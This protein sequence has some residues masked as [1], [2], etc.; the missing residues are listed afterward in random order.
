MTATISIK[1]VSERDI[2]LL[3]LEEFQSSQSFRDWFV[4][5]TFGPDVSLG[6]FIGAERS[7][8]H[9]IGESD[10]EVRFLGKENLRTRLMIENKINASL[11][12]MQAERYLEKG[13]VYVK[14]GKCSAFHT[15]IVAPSSYFGKSNSNK[16]FGHRI[17]YEQIKDW[18]QQEEGLGERRHYK[19]T[20]LK[21]AIDKGMLGYQPEEDASITS[22]WR[23][24]WHLANGLAP[25]LEMREPQ[26]K[27]S[28]SGFVHFRPTPRPPGVD[29]VHKMNH[30]FVDLHLR[31]M[32]KHVNYVREA[33]KPFLEEEMGVAS[34]SGSAAV[35]F[36]VPKLRP[37]D[38]I[39]SQAQN[40]CAGI[41]KAK[42]LLVWGRRHA[43]VIAKVFE[44]KP[45][46]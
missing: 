28:G 11:Q 33:L 46:P 20:L 30:G 24:Y 26:G 2:D 27:P 42:Q 38:S 34:A 31:G 1:G 41:D 18:F 39:D 12:P 19:L 3:L 45:Q 4:A 32:G 29:I 21:S 35:R 25:E 10:L 43:S 13:Q 9:S 23:A 5:Q 40:T 7:A 14:Q 36:T 44:Q 16:G 8:T 37:F 17:T 6:K 15:I 22:F